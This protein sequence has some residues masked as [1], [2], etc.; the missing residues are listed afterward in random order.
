MMKKKKR[1]VNTIQVNNSR[2]QN[3]INCQLFIIHYFVC[4]V[5]VIQNQGLIEKN[6]LGVGNV[7]TPTTRYVLG[8]YTLYRGM[9]IQE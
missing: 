9:Y 2:L 4:H 6:N 3:I 8:Y 1:F 5:M 7:N